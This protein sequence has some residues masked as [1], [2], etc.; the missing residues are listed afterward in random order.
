MKTTIKREAERLEVR[1]IVLDAARRLFIEGGYANVPIRNIAAAVDYSPAAL[2]RYF[3][4]KDELFA[5]LK[6]EGF[7]LLMSRELLPRRPSEPSPIER[8]RH[9]FWGVY[10]FAKLY[11][12]YFYLM[13]LDRSAPR[14]PRQSPALRVVREMYAHVGELLEECVE[15]GDVMPGL[16][17]VTVYNVLVWSVH[18]IAAG[19]VCDRLAEG[20]DPDA[21]A[22]AVLDTAIAGIR[23][24]SLAG[25]NTAVR[26][27]SKAR[28]QAR[29]PRRNSLRRGKA[30]RRS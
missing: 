4:T 21:L 2:Y 10:D 5:A 27:R 23:S 7:R 15:A 29:R 13:F 16:D 9:F 6:E 19:Y 14:A 11:P 17:P 12:E 3:K 24:G 22:H 20:T 18:G 25:I 8:L 26:H 30:A 28:P 1:R